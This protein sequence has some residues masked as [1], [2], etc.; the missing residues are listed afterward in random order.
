VQ[1]TT[2]KHQSTKISVGNIADAATA[3]RLRPVEVTFTTIL[4]NLMA[5]QWQ[6][7]YKLIY[8]SGTLWLQKYRNSTYKTKPSIKLAY[9]ANKGIV[10]LAEISTKVINNC[11]A[12]GFKPVKVILNS[13]SQ[14][15]KTKINYFFYL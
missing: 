2:Y 3:T 7:L 13:S 4:Y 14:C 15:T 12:S 9:G 5:P 8:N 11:I 10:V 6:R 1:G